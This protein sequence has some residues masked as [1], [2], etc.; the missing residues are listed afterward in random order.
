MF[1]LSMRFH[2]KRVA[3]LCCAAAVCATAF[4]GVKKLSAPKAQPAESV[5]SVRQVK[6]KVKDNQQRV[7]F[8]TG[9]GWQVVEEPEEVCDVLLPEEMDDV[10]E[11]YNQ[12]QKLQGYDLEKY[13]GKTVKRYTYIVVNY[14]G[15]EENI[16]AHIFVYKE[17]VIGGDI[18]SL[19]AENGFLHGFELT[20]ATKSCQII[21]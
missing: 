7:D 17:K 6:A 15:H 2:G 9:F 14:P 1:V 16:R 11:Q 8:L 18:C 20:E 3:A 5:A 21:L 4:W 12:I 10:I 19:E 13:L